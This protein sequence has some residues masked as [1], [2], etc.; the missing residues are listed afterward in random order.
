MARIAAPRPLP[1]PT[2]ILASDIDNT[3]TGDRGALTGF[4][5][6]RRQ[7]HALFAVATGRTIT[8]ARRILAEWDIEEPDAFITSVGTEIYRR[9]ATGRLVFDETWAQVRTPDCRVAL[10]HHCVFSL[11]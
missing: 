5:E 3:L 10:L 9:D 8:E 2:R 1:A 6:W 7:C 11:K 4:A